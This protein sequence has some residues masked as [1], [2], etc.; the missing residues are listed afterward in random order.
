[1]Y[2]GNQNPVQPRKDGNNIDD[3][4]RIRTSK[5]FMLRLNL[6]NLVAS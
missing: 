4:T 6:I 3:K 1:M 2:S 5:S